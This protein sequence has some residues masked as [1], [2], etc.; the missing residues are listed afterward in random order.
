MAAAAERERE[1]ERERELAAGALA[2]NTV[3]NQKSE[4]GVE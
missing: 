1:R 4:V 2:Y 3:R